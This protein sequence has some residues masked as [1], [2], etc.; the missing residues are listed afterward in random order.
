MK[1]IQSISAVSKR[2]RKVFMLSEN[3]EIKIVI[4]ETHLNPYVNVKAF[5][6]KALC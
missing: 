3:R 4:R 1:K 6:N 2:S 5:C